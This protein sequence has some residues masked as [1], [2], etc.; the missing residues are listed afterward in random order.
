MQAHTSKTDCRG[1]HCDLEQHMSCLTYMF[2]YGFRQFLIRSAGRYYFGGTLLFSDNLQTHLGALL[3]S[4][5]LLIGKLRYLIFIRYTQFWWIFNFFNMKAISKL[6]IS[7]CND[8]STPDIYTILF[9]RMK[10]KI[11]PCMHMNWCSHGII[12][13]FSIAR[14]GQFRKNWA[15]KRFC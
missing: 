10:K 13:P 7:Y 14:I 9:Q 8:T 6:H 2:V 4:R 3:L 1:C 12:V 15:W 5:V 11:L